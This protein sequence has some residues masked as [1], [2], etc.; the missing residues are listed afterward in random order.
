MSIGQEGQRDVEAL[1]WKR[2]RG[3]DV[4]TRNF[5]MLNMSLLSK[6]EQFACL[7]MGDTWDV[8]EEAI[9][10]QLSVKAIFYRFSSRMMMGLVLL[11]QK[12]SDFGLKVSHLCHQRP[13]GRFFRSYASVHSNVD[14]SIIILLWSN[15]PTIGG[16]WTAVEGVQLIVKLSPCKNHDK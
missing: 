8:K 1:S 9:E 7:N 11:R 10:R 3:H 15:V 13:S 6:S 5:G 14:L 16:E 4:Q 2:E 12:I